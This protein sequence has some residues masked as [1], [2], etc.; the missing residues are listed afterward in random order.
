MQ[1]TQNTL[2][3][4]SLVIAMAYVVF[5]FGGLSGQVKANSVKFNDYRV[6]RKDMSKTLK[7]IESRLIKIET[8]LEL[9]AK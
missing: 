7:N 5:N 4:I 2:L 6:E 1:I 8:S 9:L 3:P